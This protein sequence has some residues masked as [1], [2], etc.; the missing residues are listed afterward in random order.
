M[1]EATRE[2]SHYHEF[3]YLIINDDFDSALM[4]LH[5]IFVAKRQTLNYQKTKHVSL[6]SQLIPT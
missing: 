2:L 4:H 6:L 3:E 5:S 1:S